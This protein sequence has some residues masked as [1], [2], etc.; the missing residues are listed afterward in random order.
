M[1][2]LSKKESTKAEL[3]E[4]AEYGIHKMHR[5]DLDILL[6]KMRERKLITKHPNPHL[7][8]SMLFAL[9]ERGVELATMIKDANDKD[10]LFDLD[11]FHNVKSLGLSNG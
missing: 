4:K 3:Q 6:E 1:F 7:K 11:A 2:L 9:T 5:I 10:P 8:K